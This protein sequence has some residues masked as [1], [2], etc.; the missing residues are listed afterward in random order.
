MGP[1]KEAQK[2]VARAFGARQSFFVTNGT[3]TANKIVT[4]ALVR[5]RITS[6]NVCYTK[7]LRPHHIKPQV[8]CQVTCSAPDIAALFC[9]WLNELLYQAEIHSA[10]WR[11]ARVFGRSAA[12]GG[13]SS[14][15]QSEEPTRPAQKKTARLAISRARNNFV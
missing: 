13:S 6:Y 12:G 7:L 3:S 4:Q 10:L 14:Q 15:H 11:N 2:K 8:V 1:I 5:P 9:E